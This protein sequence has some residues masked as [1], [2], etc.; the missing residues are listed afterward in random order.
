MPDTSKIFNPSEVV[1]QFM[2]FSPLQPN[3]KRIPTKM[4]ENCSVR[5]V[6]LVRRAPLYAVCRVSIRGGHALQFLG[7]SMVHIELHILYMVVICHLSKERK[8]PWTW[9]NGRIEGWKK[10][11]E[12]T[13]FLAAREQ[14]YSPPM[15]SSV[16]GIELSWVELAIL[17]FLTFPFIYLVPSRYTSY[18]YIYTC[19]AL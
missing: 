4:A 11:K 9:A 5:K 2:W 1:I 15:L 6:T 16:V 7:W 10:I 13:M 19:T 17:H 18:V 12:N 8:S 14:L 3:R